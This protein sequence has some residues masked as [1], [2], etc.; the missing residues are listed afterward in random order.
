VKRLTR[1]ITSLMP[2]FVWSAQRHA[3]QRPAE[4]RPAA[5]AC[6]AA[7]SRRHLKNGSL[8]SCDASHLSS[9][10]DVIPVISAEILSRADRIIATASS[11]FSVLFI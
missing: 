1:D 11:F 10:S 5:L 2:V 7:R 3:D 4:G 8:S 6:R 9:S